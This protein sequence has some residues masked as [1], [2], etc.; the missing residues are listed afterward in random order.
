MTRS[1]LLGALRLLRERGWLLTL[2]GVIALSVAFVRL[3]EWQHDRYLAKAERNHWIDANYSAA[4]VPLASLLPAVDTTLATD[5]Q[6]RSATVSGSYQADAQVLVRNRSLGSAAGFEVIVPLRL[7]DGPTLW[8]DRG[9]LPLGTTGDVPD[10]IPEPPTGPVHLVVRLLR[11]EPPLDRAPPAGQVWRIN[12]A[13]LAALSPGPSYQAYGV[14]VSDSP[15][16]DPAPAPLP[17]PDEDLGPHLGYAWQWWMF[18]VAGFLVLGYYLLREARLR[19]GNPEPLR[20]RLP[21]LVSAMTRSGRG[22]PSDE[23]WEDAADRGVQP[24]VGQRVGPR[25]FGVDDHQPGS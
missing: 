8:I 19:S 10:H 18:A 7:A 21:A 6:W 12:P 11:P 15:A 14:L 23:E 25:R 22:E 1:D 13:A 3:G 4:P 17:R 2:L 5:L 24:D 16:A 20:V 9:W